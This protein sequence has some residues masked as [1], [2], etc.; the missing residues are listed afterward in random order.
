MI[1]SAIARRHRAPLTFTGNIAAPSSA[2]TQL[3]SRHARL[4]MVTTLQS[5]T[6]IE[7]EWRALEQSNI[8]PASV[9]QNFSWVY[10]WAAVYA[11]A[12]GWAELAVVTGYEGGRLVFVLPL[13]QQT[14]MGITT[15]KWLTEPSGQYGDILVAEGQDAATWMQS[16]V[17]YLKRLKG[18]DIIRLRHVRADAHVAGYLKDQFHDARHNERAA[19][20][21]LTAFPDEAAYD[22]RYT[23]TQRK[24]RKKIRKELEQRGPMTFTVLPAGA[25][26]DAAIDAAIREK[27]A[28]LAERGRQNRILHCPGHLTFLKTLSRSSDPEFRMEVSEL[29][30]GDE[31]V[32]WEIGF[33]HRGTH[34]GYITSHVNK[35]T[36]L[37]PGRLHMDQSQRNCVKQGLQKFDLMVPYD[38]HKESWSS[39]TVTA[40]DYY[41]P[42][43]LR[44][45]VFGKL[46]L[47]LL[48]PAIRRIYL[49]APQG[50][51]RAIVPIFDR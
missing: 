29:C 14:A 10:N 31:P 2:P 17:S 43:S 38:A 46:Y 44:G 50:L 8:A 16:A 27:N 24:R 25:R 5:L 3:L 7:H 28:W 33:S 6:A 32:S 47:C 35:L 39:N 4:S 21:D 40:A 49:K 12:E 20:L 19:Y 51:L 45:R 42:L 41:Y 30:F 1:A 23:P 9:F 18:V 11:K 22:A 34:Y 15:L 36:D 26:A 48:R 13:M 37:S